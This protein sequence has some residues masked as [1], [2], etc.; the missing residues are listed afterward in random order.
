MKKLSL[1]IMASLVLLACKTQPNKAKSDA[2]PQD[3]AE[4]ITSAELETYLTKFASE[5][6]EGRG[7]GLPGQKKAAE[8]LANHYKDLG[9]EP[10]NNSSYFQEIPADFLGDEYGDTE[11][12][13]AF[14]EGSE[15]PEEILVLSAHYDH[16]GIDDDGTIYYGADDDGSGTVA[17][18]EIAEAFKLAAEDGNGPKK[19]I[20]F[21]H[22]SAEEIGLLGSKYYAENPVFPLENTVANLNIDM[23]GRTDTEYQAEVDYIYIIGADRISQELHDINEAAN[24]EFAEIE[25]DYKYN[26]EDEPMRLYYRSDHYNFAKNGIPSIFYFSGLHED[27]HKSTDTADK[28]NY[29]LMTKR[30]KLIFHTA[31]K[32][33]NK[34]GR[35]KID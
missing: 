20:L 14:I 31:W 27:Y 25:L 17:L 9:I 6:F 11:N 34:D 1:I 24:N 4:S 18:L 33:A 21:L 35:L 5:E 3:Y 28:I 19:S 12:V 15:K 13:L 26:A 2:K 32:I 30:T 16:L 8:Y 22:V 10:G 7:T 29:D 23:I